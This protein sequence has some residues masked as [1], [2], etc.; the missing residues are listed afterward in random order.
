MTENLHKALESF[1]VGWC[2]ITHTNPIL[3]WLG[4]QRVHNTPE[5]KHLE[6]LRMGANIIAYCFAYAN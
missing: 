1:T 2:C 5:E 4:R 3:K 6:A